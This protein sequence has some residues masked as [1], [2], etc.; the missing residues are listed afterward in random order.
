MKSS[1]HEDSL[2]DGDIVGPDNTAAG[3]ARDR[4][5]LPKEIT[6]SSLASLSHVSSSRCSS[7]APS[8]FAS[9]SFLVS[10]VPSLS[11]LFSS[12]S[13]NS[14]VE[15]SIFFAKYSSIFNE[16]GEFKNSESFTPFSSSKSC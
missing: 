5:R 2:T 8:S 14:L 1:A 12:V 9:S 3:G 11:C 16:A 6:E 10:C 7:P 15:Q 13:D 4:P